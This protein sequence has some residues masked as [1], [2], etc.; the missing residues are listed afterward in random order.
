MYEI[1]RKLQYITSTGQN[2]GSVEGV[3]L[4]IHITKIKVWIV[5]NM[6][7]MEAS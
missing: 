6:R 2:I 7:L 5:F 1:D 4:Y 3:G